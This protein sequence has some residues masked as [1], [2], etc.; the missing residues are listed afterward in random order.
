MLDVDRFKG[1]NDS[2]GHLAGDQLLRDLANT[3]TQVAKKENTFRYGGDELAVLLPGVSCLAAVE[4]A[5]SLRNAVLEMGGEPMT[6]S[7]GVGCFPETASSA[8]E[9]IYRAD[10]AMYWAKSSGRNCVANW[11]D[12]QGAEVSHARPPY[13]DDHGAR[14]DI[15]AALCAALKAKD[16]KTRKQA[17]RCSWYAAELATELG[18]SEADVS[19]LR[20]ALRSSAPGASPANQPTS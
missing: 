15:V 1:I 2:L 3:L 6:I 19:M 16:V 20:G 18:L 12:L 17:E 4:V 14:H 7:L 8:E 11:N 13:T 9:L 10:M 5:E